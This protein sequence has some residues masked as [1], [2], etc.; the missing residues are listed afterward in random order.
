MLIGNPVDFDRIRA[1]YEALKYPT[2][3]EAAYNATRARYEG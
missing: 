2:P 1:R 3:E